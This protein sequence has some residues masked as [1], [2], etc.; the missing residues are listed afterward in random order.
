MNVL[1]PFQLEIIELDS[2]ELPFDYLRQHEA[3]QLIEATTDRDHLLLNT[4]W[5]T[6]ARISEILTLRPCDIDGN[7]ITIVTLKKRKC[8]NRRTK[9][10]S[11]VNLPKTIL[12]QKQARRI[13][14]IMIN[15]EG[16][17][18]RNLI[19]SGRRD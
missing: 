14:P 2:H 3:R 18:L 16:N 19:P 13:I 12:K 5:Q 9:S 4:M 8:T 17:A 7:G 6:G 1:I 11:W 10:G 15:C